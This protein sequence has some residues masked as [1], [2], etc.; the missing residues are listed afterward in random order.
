MIGNYIKATSGGGGS[1]T[2]AKLMKTGQT[3]SY[4]TGD[5]GDLQEGR[6]VDFFTLAENNV[7]GTTDRF[8]DELGTQVY[9]NDIVIDWSTYNGSEVLG[10]YR[11]RGS[12]NDIVWNDAIDNSLLFSVGGFASGWRLPNVTEFLSIFS[13]ANLN[14][15]NRPLGYAPFDTLPV[16][17]YWTSTTYPTSTGNAYVMSNQYLST[18]NFITT[19]A[20]TNTSIGYRAI[21]CRTFTVTGTTLS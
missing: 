15:L 11:I 10:W 14:T 16:G 17:Y 2:T 7:F 20:K 12:Y 18:P 13:L 4:R 5:D 6:D 3:I 8:T 21:P 9:A 1:L 19:R